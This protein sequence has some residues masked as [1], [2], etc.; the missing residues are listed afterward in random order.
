[1]LKNTVIIEQITTI[2]GEKTR[3]SIAYVSPLTAAFYRLLWRVNGV[4]RRLYRESA[5][6]RLFYRFTSV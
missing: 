6:K 3:H 5:L 2:N 1:M 4:F